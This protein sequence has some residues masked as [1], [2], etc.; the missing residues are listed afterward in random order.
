MQIYNDS[1][2]NP[3]VQIDE[4]RPHI[5]RHLDELIGRLPLVAQKIA[6]E[7][8]YSELDKIEA[9][10]KEKAAEVAAEVEKAEKKVREKAG[11]PTRPTVFVQTENP[12][13]GSPFTIGFSGSSGDSHAWIGIYPLGTP[14]IG[15]GS[16]W[17]YVS[18][19]QQPGKGKVAGS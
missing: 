1:L 17:L 4:V 8:A 19:T 2:A 6:R 5:E 18:G 11:F 10:A 14:H 3:D 9:R 7:R 15:H 13:E 16:N 12:Q